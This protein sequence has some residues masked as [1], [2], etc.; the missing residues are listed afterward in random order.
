[1]ARRK[2]AKSSPISANNFTIT[3]LEPLTDTQSTF[4]DNYDSGKSQ[5]LL[6]YAGTGKSIL[7]IYTALAEIDDPDS[8]YQRRVIVRSAVPTREVGHLP[9]DLN[10]KGAVY[11]LP[12][13][14]I[15]SELMGRD[16]AY[17]I[18]KQKD[19]IRFVTT[20]FIRGLTIDNAIIVVDEFQSLNGHELDSIITRVGHNSKILFCG[21]LLQ[22]DLIRNH[23]KA[24]AKKFLDILR[25]MPEYFDFNEFGKDDI[26]RSGLVKN[27]IIKKMD[28]YP[29]GL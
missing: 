16:D 21:D 17:E 23:E 9:G 15:C 4:F 12:Y 1:M 26:V 18:L 11:E 13:K 8:D 10:E 5:I 19:I 6:G 2:P 27:Y 28:T 24:G 25:S 29:E 3:D 22:S 7:A 14:K 20:S